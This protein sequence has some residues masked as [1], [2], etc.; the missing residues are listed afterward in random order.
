MNFKDL[1]EEVFSVDKPLNEMALRHLE[2][3]DKFWKKGD[4][5]AVADKYIENALK[6]NLDYTRILRG[7]TTTFKSKTLDH[8]REAAD[9][10]RDIIRE[11]VR[12]LQA[13][14]K[15]KNKKE[16]ESLKKVT[17]IKKTEKQEE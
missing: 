11:K 5:D 15:E 1:L 7:L 12:K 10:V 13:D 17:L 9:K 8:N 3:T 4:L 16:A 2:G 6:D 14:E